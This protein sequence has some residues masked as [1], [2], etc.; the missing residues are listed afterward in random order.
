MILNRISSLPMAWCLEIELGNEAASDSI[1][2]NLI[3][4]L[5]NH[6]PPVLGGRPPTHDH[7]KS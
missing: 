7:A 3:S 1:C 5:G 2:E 4:R 6:R